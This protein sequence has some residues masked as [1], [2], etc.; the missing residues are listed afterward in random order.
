MV[1]EVLQ[2][3]HHRVIGIWMSEFSKLLKGT[4]LREVFAEIPSV[5]DEGI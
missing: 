1:I 4:V 2:R 5:C 3:F